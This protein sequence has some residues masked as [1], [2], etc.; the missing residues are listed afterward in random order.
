MC[1]LP[2][3][4]KSLGYDVTVNVTLGLS[5]LVLSLQQH[6]TSLLLVIKPLLEKVH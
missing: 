6:S 1:M 2:Q 5:N 4:E 3:V